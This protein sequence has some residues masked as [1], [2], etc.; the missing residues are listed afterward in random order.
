MLTYQTILSPLD[1]FEIRNLFSIDTPLLANINLSI[2][3]IGLY[4]TIAAFIAFYY[5]VLATNHSKITPNKWS[6][7][8]ETLYATIHS[9]VVNQIN[10]KSGQAY[11]PFMYALFIFILINNLIGMVNRSLRIYII[12]TFSL[13]NLKNKIIRL[14][15]S[16]TSNY[17]RYN[18][19]NTYRLNPYYI[20]GL[21]DAEGC[22]T[23]S[24]Y[25]DCRMKTG[26]QIKPIFQL[27][28]HKKDIKILEA[29]QKTWGVGKIYKHGEDSLMYRVS[30]LKNLRVITNHFDIYPLITQKHSDYLLFKQSIN[31]IDKKLHLT[32]I[33]LLKLVGIKSVL[34]WGLSEK[35][36]E[37]FP[38]M[39]AVVRPKVNISEIK[40]VY[41]LIG[42]VE[43]EGSFMIT[44][45][46]SKSKK[47]TDNI[48]LRFSMTQHSKDLVLLDNIS[49][50]LGCGKLYFSRNEVNLIV[51]TFSDINLKIISLFNKYPLLGTKKEDYLDFCKVAE[52]MKSKDH[53]TKEGIENI[54]IIKSNMN[55]K[56]IHS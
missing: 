38:N 16:N 40:D 47:T 11:F 33:G 20:T 2:T 44:I 35:F 31:L 42:F 14:Y 29:I 8:Q 49:K 37:T 17:P 24:I 43:G 46:E 4:M 56:R 5:S 23:T 3:N 51:S 48:S 1:Q 27:N 22:F 53:L 32:E 6:L 13:T 30:S 50:Y 45:Q 34:N 10:N 55:S 54:K 21:V 39:I 41:W 15:S 9:I 52:L 28:L 25:K 18:L 7:S 19:N 36:K 26:W 12:K